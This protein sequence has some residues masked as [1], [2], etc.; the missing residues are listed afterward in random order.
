MAEGRR[1]E[2]ADVVLWVEQQGIFRSDR[3]SG[4]DGVVPMRGLP[5][6]LVLDGGLAPG[7][8]ALGAPAGDGGGRADAEGHRG[9]QAGRHAHRGRGGRAGRARGGRHAGGDAPRRGAGA[10]ATRAGTSRFARCGRS[11]A[12]AWRRS[13]RATTRW[14]RAEGTPGG[15]AGEGGAQAPARL[16]RAAWWADDGAPVRRFRLDEHDVSS[17]DG[18]FEVSLPIGG[19][20]RHRLGGCA[21]LRADDGG[22]ARGAGSGRSGAAEGADAPGLVRDEGGGPVTDA[23]V[24]C[25]V[26]DESVLSGP[27]GRF[28]ISS[29]PYVAQFSVSAR[30]GRLS[31]DAD[32]EPWQR[33]PRGADAAAR[34]AA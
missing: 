15:P 24:T 23:V 19:G 17:P 6:G 8:P 30:K 16:P 18:R 1:V 25:E 14:T 33:R 12:T 7:L 34:D 2:G 31:G 13:T 22:S 32:A 21:G 27:D 20:S 3:P 11:G 28:T 10:R 9:A 29:P 26:C 5:D 4:P